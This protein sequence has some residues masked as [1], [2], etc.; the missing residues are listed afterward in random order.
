MSIIG[1]SGDDGASSVIG[2][3]SAKAM[4]SVFDS[5]EAA[6]GIDLAALIQGQTFGRG[7]GTAGWWARRQTH[8]ALMHSYDMLSAVG[9][10]EEWQPDPAVA[11]DGVREVQDTFYLRQVKMARTEPLAGT[12]V[13]E[14]TDVPGGADPV[15]IGDGEPHVHLRGTARELLLL[16]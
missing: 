13:L 9:R 3:D 4:R 15:R 14:A 2:G 11:W 12:L 5:V 8:E 10:E 16:L 7:V 1:G 6:T